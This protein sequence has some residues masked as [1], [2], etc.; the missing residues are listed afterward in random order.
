MTALAVAAAISLA[1][2]QEAFDRGD[3]AQA[4]SLAVRGEPDGAALYLAALARFRAG[5]P[6]GALE[7]LD[8][9]AAAQS[10]PDAA[11]WRFNR[12]ACLYELGRYAE[13][14][15]DYL[16]A[17]EEPSLAVAALVDAAFAALDSGSIPRAKDLA[18]QARAKATDERGLDL[19]ADLDAHVSAAE[20][21][22]ALAVYKDGLDAYD[23][24]DYTSARER[25]LR[26]VKLDP[27]DGRSRIM[28]AASA[29]RLGDRTAAR[30]ELDRALT[31][32][33]DES[34]ART[35]HAYLD[36][37]AKGGRFE[38]TARLAVGF[39]SN[40]QQSG[41]LQADEFPTALAASPSA[42]SSADVALTWRAPP[43]DDG[44][45]FGFDYDLAQLAYLD[46]AAADRSLQ[47]HTL[48]FTLQ[49]PLSERLRAGLLFGGEMDFAGL[50]NFRML[51]GVARIGG[52]LSFVETERTTTRLDLALSRKQGG[53]AEFSYL[54]GNRADAALTQDL[55]LGSLTLTGGY[56]F[57]FEDIGS[58][59][60]G[61]ATC[62]VS[63]CAG[64]VEAFGYR[65][66]TFWASA[67]AQPHP[68]VTLELVGGVELRSYLGDDWT[69]VRG[70]D[71][72]LER[73]DRLVFGSVSATMRASSRVAA[74]LRY[75][76]VD[77]R[78]NLPSV[79]N[80]PAGPP[81]R[82]YTKQVLSLGTLFWW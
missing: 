30:T 18:A 72:G 1:S 26:A 82:S 35:A 66:H 75:D 38:G 7:L 43:R 28:A 52:F 40:P 41:L 34:D 13:A 48:S 47:Q 63:G 74:S 15:T 16:R 31:L 29:F 12:A 9:S 14:E 57:R 46:Q 4:E 3:Y 73:K 33:L 67:R 36:L 42:L 70:S 69:M 65:G 44:L 55:A 10:P 60:V 39:D 78:S 23:A 76:L 20:H 54:T 51:Q 71:S 17:A 77:N 50:G 81:D 79:L 2:A 6:Q 37:L 19:V 45:V 5:D 59:A 32:H 62:V 61:S 24:G 27:T 68:R 22:K 21:Q 64:F 8:R 25:F 53:S 49:T 56:A 80:G 58:D 11:L